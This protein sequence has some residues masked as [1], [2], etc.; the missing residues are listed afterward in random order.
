[1]RIAPVLMTAVLA[2]GCFKPDYR[3]GDLRCSPTGGCPSGMMCSPV[4]NHCYKPG[5]GPPPISTPD[6]LAMPADDLAHA[7]DDLAMPD[8]GP[9]V[10]VPGSPRNVVASA[11][12]A[13]ATITWAEPSSNGNSPITGYEVKSTPGGVTKTTDGSTLTVTFT[14]LNNGTQYKFDVAAIN[15]AG[16]GPATSSNGATP[17]ASPVVPAAPTNVTAALSGPLAVLV[18]W[19][20]ADNGGAEI[21]G[22][23]I[24]STTGNVSAKAGKGAVSA[25]VSGLTA[26]QRY[27]FMVTATNKV[28]DSLPSSPSPEVIA[29]NIPDAPTG[30][31]AIAIAGQKATIQWAASNGNGSTVSTYTVTAAPGGATWTSAS[32]SK[33]VDSLTAGQSYTFTVTATNA[34]G[35]S[36]PSSPTTAILAGDLPGGVAPVTATADRPRGVTVSW[37]AAQDNGSPLSGYTVSWTGGSN[38]S[39]PAG[40]TDTSAVV[41]NLVAGAKYKFTVVAKNGFGDGP[42]AS[43]ADVTIL[44]TPAAPSNVQVCSAHQQ[45]TVS[46]QPVAGATSYNLYYSTDP[47]VSKTNGTKVANIANPATVTLGQGPPKYYLVVTAVGPVGESSESTPPQTATPD[48]LPRDRLFAV[49]GSAVQIFDCYSAMGANPQPTRTLSYPGQASDQAGIDVSSGAIYSVRSSRPA[50]DKW[51]SSTLV[52]GTRDPDESLV[53]P[54]TTLKQPAS[55][56]VDY[57]RSKIYVA[58]LGDSSLKIYDVSFGLGDRAPYVTIPNLPCAQLSLDQPADQL[59]CV[60]KDFEQVNVYHNASSIFSSATAASRT[61]KIPSAQFTA[62][63]VD[64]STNTLYLGNALNVLHFDNASNL[65]GN[66]PFSSLSI[67]QTLPTGPA[68]SLHAVNGT[69]F[70]GSGA[71]FRQWNG[72]RSRV[73]SD[74]NVTGGVVPARGNALFYYP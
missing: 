32:T 66:L 17:T 18:T 63:S 13:S 46:Y 51:T 58:D 2:S 11:G 48:G 20:P 71:D 4:D 45:A 70:A 54:S 69:L 34:V 25:V 40:K 26:G 53:G 56:Q 52:S 23:T 6:D 19:S 74:P 65:S 57:K 38:G 42:A 41:T 1:M 73:Q 24:T 9:E 61:M 15:A 49:S 22:Y 36:D 31:T 33:T 30:V 29:A 27:K 72:A 8:L 37:S 67:L 7:A 43:S 14:G 21:T 55:V 16:K 60:I 3:S 35:T 47:N 62:I 68:A 64:P 5:A 10:T 59:Y 39:Q 28:G 50:V 12:D 44:D